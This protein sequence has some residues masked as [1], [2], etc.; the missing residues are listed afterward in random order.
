MKANKQHMDNGVADRG[1]ILEPTKNLTCNVVMAP[2]EII[3]GTTETGLFL[4]RDTIGT[5]GQAGFDMFSNFVDTFTGLTEPKYGK[6]RKTM[7]AT[8]H[9]ESFRRKEERGDVGSVP[10]PAAAE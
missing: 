9:E 10:I 6:K 8:K 1:G 7:V 5:V 3:L 2:V 4:C